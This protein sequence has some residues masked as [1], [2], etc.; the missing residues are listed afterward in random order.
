[1]N[2]PI[3]LVDDDE[4]VLAALNSYLTMEGYE[5]RTARNSK[6]CF[7][8]MVEYHPSLILLDVMLPEENGIELLKRIKTSAPQIPVIMITGLMNDEIGRLALQ[9]SACDYI[10]KPIDLHYLKDVINMQR[11]G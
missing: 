2:G 7:R 1:M 10:T 11:A 4:D 5:I 3:L 9:E 6:E 8:Q